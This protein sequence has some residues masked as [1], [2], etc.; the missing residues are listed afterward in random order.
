M[1][2]P[3]AGY[4]PGTPKPQQAEAAPAALLTGAVAPRR[5]YCTFLLEDEIYGAET[6]PIQEVIIPPR[7]FSVPTAPPE[8]LGVVNLRGSLIP[9][10]D[11]KLIVKQTPWRHTPE[12]RILVVKQRSLQAG[13]AV[14]SI[15]QVVEVGETDLSPFEI[16]SDDRRGR[17]LIHLARLPGN[18]FISLDL[19]KI[20][21][22]HRIR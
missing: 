16:G 6:F 12:S 22:E 17:Y 10:V 19:T 14:D 21:T 11:L 4:S 3:Y 18:L 5:Q 8:L 9:I 7:I 13:F 2:E 1:M 15:Q 20:L